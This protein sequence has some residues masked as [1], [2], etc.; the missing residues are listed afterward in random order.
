[1]KFKILQN[2][3]KSLINLRKI[4]KKKKFNFKSIA[5]SMKDL[6]QQ[7]LMILKNV[8]MDNNIKEYR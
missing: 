3:N 4:Q 6:K 7:K 2:L 8:W 5:E 1:M